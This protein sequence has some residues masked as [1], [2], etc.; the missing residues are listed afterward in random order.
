MTDISNYDISAHHYI[1]AFRV[2]TSILKKA[3]LHPDAVTF[4]LATFMNAGGQCRLVPYN[5]IFTTAWKMYR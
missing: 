4:P 3:A 2:L 5:S 1:G